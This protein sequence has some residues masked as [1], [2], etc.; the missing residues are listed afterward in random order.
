MINLKIKTYFIKLS[1][2]DLILLESDGYVFLVVGG[3]FVDFIIVGVLT[4][5]LG[6][7]VIVI[8]FDLNVFRIYCTALDLVSEFSNIL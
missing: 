2:I 7:F 1:Q 3:L 4:L 5:I 6:V 8:E